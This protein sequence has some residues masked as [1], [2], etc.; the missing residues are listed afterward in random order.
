[1][2]L[3]TG[4]GSASV[5]AGIPHP[6]ARRPPGKADTPCKETPLAKADTTTPGKADIPW[7]GRH[8]PGKDPLAR[9]PL[10][11]TPLRSAHIC[12]DNSENEYSYA[13]KILEVLV[14]TAHNRV[15]EGNALLADITKY[16]VPIS[17]RAWLYEA[18][19]R[20]L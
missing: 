12:F 17:E 2:I 16:G 13:P 4:G 7:Q 20:L 15:W 19:L 6:P 18:F 9:T 8:P 3:F 1:M 5:H 14:F 11:R 10:A